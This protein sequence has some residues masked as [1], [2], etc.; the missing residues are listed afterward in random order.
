MS[1]PFSPGLLVFNQ[2]RVFV[3]SLAVTYISKYSENSSKGLT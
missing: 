3:T 1:D 2:T